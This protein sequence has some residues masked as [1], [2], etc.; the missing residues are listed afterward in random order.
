[1][2]RLRQVDVVCVARRLR[3]PS[4]LYMPGQPGELV[5]IVMLREFLGALLFRFVRDAWQARVCVCRKP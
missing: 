4:V 2:D 5:S 1:M 3:P